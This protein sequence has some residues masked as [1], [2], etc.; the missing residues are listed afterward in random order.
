[1]TP[2]DQAG[3]HNFLEVIGDRSTTRSTFIVVLCELKPLR[4]CGTSLSG[5]TG[6]VE[7]DS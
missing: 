6:G 5:I 7:W 1:M 4:Y 3:R 2:L